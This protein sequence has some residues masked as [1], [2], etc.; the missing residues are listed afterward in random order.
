[1]PKGAALPFCR[2][3]FSAVVDQA[4][5]KVQFSLS[6]GPV[7]HGLSADR[8]PVWVWL[9]GLW[10]PDPGQPRVHTLEGAERFT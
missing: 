7:V 10:D 1:M 4:V 6:K 8:R 5:M 2:T 3:T 9:R